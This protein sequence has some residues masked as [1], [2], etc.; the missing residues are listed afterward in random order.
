MKSAASALVDLKTYSK[1]RT[2]F[3]KKRNTEILAKRAEIMAKDPSLPKIAAYQKALKQLW[4][5]QDQD[6]WE[7]RATGEANDIYE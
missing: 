5:N 1:G 6:V 3:K 7:A 4:S 2:L